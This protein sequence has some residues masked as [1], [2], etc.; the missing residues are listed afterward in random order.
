MTL[1]IKL[2][3][4][5]LSLVVLLSPCV[6]NVT[7]A[8]LPDTSS[9]NRIADSLL[10]VSEIPEIAYAVVKPDNILFIQTRGF[11]K[12][13]LKD[14]QNAA[15]LSDYFHL[16]SNTKAITGFIAAH[17]VE[18]GKISW[19]TKFFDLFPAMKKES[20]AAFYNISLSDL[21]SHRA[22]IKPYTS[23]LEYKFLPEFKGNP[24]EKRMQFVQ[25]ILKGLPVEKNSKVYNYSNA[26]YSVAALM[27]ERVSGMTWEALV[28]KVLHKELALSYKLGWPNKAD[29]DQPW[30]HWM[31]NKKLTPVPGDIKYNL[32]LAEP[33]GDI[34]MPLQ[35]YAKFI[36]LNLKGLSGEHNYLKSSTY[37]FLHYGKKDYSIGWA[38]ISTDQE[39]LSD[40]AGSAGT[41]YAYTQIDKRNQIAYVIF[42][43]SATQ[44]AQKAVHDL[45]TH[46]ASRYGK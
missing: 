41:F 14:A 10:V 5:R 4:R 29:K 17:L 34:S 21:L 40:H 8:Q 28:E 15:N 12:V 24:S 42:A 27:L 1:N 35:D 43:N 38:N 7:F 26:G 39:Q 36:Q 18:Q 16:G 37:N 19:A 6:T 46:L 45:L 30:G 9:V 31:E 23:G 11:H 33:A 20:N 13:D 2:Y 25:Y 44:K 22:Y 32:S 3:I